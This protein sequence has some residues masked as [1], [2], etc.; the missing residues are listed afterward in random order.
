MNWLKNTLFNCREATYLIEKKTDEKITLKQALQL[1]LHLLGCGMCKLY[2]RQSAAMQKIIRD[3]MAE[4]N[5]N[6]HTNLS[7]ETKNGLQNE[8][9]NKLKS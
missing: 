9:N 1:R 6:G 5:E 7:D 3:M 8:I 4:M 2:K